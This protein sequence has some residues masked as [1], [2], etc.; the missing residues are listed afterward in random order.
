VPG[1][2]RTSAPTRAKSRRSKPRGKPNARGKLRGRHAAP[3][4]WL[5]AGRAARSLPP[6]T[7][8]KSN[9]ESCP[10]S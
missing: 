4:S 1:S 9:S 6:R 5:G 7:K 10:R 8:S 3:R 2:G